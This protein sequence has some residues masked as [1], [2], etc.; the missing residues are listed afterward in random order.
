MHEHSKGK[1]KWFPK[2]TTTSL[3]A[4]LR[5]A[6]RPLS[7]FSYKRVYNTAIVC[8]EKILLST[9]LCIQRT[10][11]NLQKYLNCNNYNTIKNLIIIIYK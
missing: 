5:H 2:P 1:N 4:V 9:Q 8:S 10:P 3:L 7:K 6:E 11:N